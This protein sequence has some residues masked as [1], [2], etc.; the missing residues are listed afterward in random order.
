M[1][2]DLQWISS[3]REVDSEEWDKI[4]P[5]N[6]PF[7]RH[8]FL[9][10]LELTNCVCKA[11]GWLPAYLLYRENGRLLGAIACYQKWH[12]YGEFIFDWS[13]ADSLQRAGLRY[14]PKLIT[15][16]PFT[17]ANGSRLLIANDAHVDQE[18][19]SSILLKE[20]YSYC[21]ERE[22][23]SYHILHQTRKEQE[24]CQANGML[25]RL[26]YQYH[27]ENNE[28]QSFDD[29][30]G[31]LRSRRRKEIRRERRSLTKEG[32]RIRKFT[33]ADLTLET[34]EVMYQFYQNTHEKKWG[35][36]YLNFDF[37]KHM[38]NTMP[39]KILIILADRDGDY[40]G[41]SFNLYSG[42]TLYGRYW[43]SAVYVP[44]LHFECCYYSLIEFAIEKKIKLVEAGAGGEHK[45]LRGFLAR[46]VYSSH[47][48][49][50]E[51]A[52]EAVK[53]FLENEWTYVQN[54]IE[55]M[56]QESPVK[57]FRREALNIE[58]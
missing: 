54:A 56:N 29:F 21:Q 4:V 26:S 2:S 53:K 12:S 17:P 19:I 42:D 52:N 45:F 14:Y 22:L 5:D 28:Y 20:V 50:H 33:G 10:G 9:E 47:L 18:R 32:V 43:G 46:E 36:A 31:S 34:L 15:S 40:L 8:T 38:Y 27:W 55:S 44:N 1:D 24:S 25:R 51:Q 7:F 58:I 6:F 41:G 3:I 13:W 57:E 48:L 37:F 30:L 11:T 35:Q 16:A 49:F 23:S 39:E